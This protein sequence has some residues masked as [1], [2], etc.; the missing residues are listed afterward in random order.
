MKK[1]LV[2]DDEQEIV[3]I[4]KEFL[5]K[6]GYSVIT[7]SGGAEAIEIIESDQELELVLLDMKMPKIKGIDLLKKMKELKIVTPFIVLSGSIEMQHHLDALGEMGYNN[8]DI[9][10]KPVDFSRLL[11]LIEE[12]L[13][14]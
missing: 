5:S 8:P 1:I 9:L 6:N 11:I 10:N 3:N 7:A 2:V 4:L 13:S 14:K 12:K